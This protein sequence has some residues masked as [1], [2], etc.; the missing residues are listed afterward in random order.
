MKKRIFAICIFLVLAALCFSSCSCDDFDITGQKATTTESTEKETEKTHS[1]EPESTPETTIETIPET[2]PEP[3]TETTTETTPET[4]YE[5]ATE[6]TIET[7]PE[8]APESMPETTAETVTETELETETTAPVTES[9][10]ENPT[11][12]DPTSYNVKFAFE[13]DKAVA[14]QEF[15][16]TLSVDSAD[17]VNVDGL[18]AYML[19]YDSNVLEFL[20]FTNYG[21]LVTSSVAGNNSISNGIVNLGYNPAVVANGNICDLS[22]RVK[23]NASAG[24]KTTISMSADAAKNRV[25]VG[26]VIAPSID[27]EIT[28]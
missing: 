7:T 24:T 10:P 23:A 2:A 20:G 27:V 21:E 15:T 5:P 11:E 28:G 16:V 14:G 4:S 3:A 17:T 18:I 8:T 12:Q 6:T 19:K 13:Y 9:T 1:I 25:S 22:F 26:K